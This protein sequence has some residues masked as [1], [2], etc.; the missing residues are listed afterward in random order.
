[1]GVN[2]LFSGEKMFL[3]NER[4]ARV[5]RLLALAACV[6]SVAACATSDADRDPWAQGARGS[7]S[8]AGPAEPIPDERFF[9]VPA[10]KLDTAE[11]WLEDKPFLALDTD[12]IRYFGQHNF[13]CP[14][15]TAPYLIR[16]VYENGGTGGFSIIRHGTTLLVRHYSLG[17]ASK[18][19][20]TGLVVCL[21]FKPTEIFHALGGAL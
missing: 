11:Y 21:D 5:L 13:A 2:N 3:K 17:R 10:S 8:E 18:M 15:R 20:R 14:E 4:A 16:A 7:L 1:M 19:R 6:S 12:G 9:E